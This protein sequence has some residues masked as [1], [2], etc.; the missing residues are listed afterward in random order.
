MNSTLHALRRNRK[1]LIGAAIMS[2]FAFLALVGPFLVADPQ[3]FV[4][5]PLTPPGS[6]FWFGT[7]GQGQ[8]VLA[9]TIVGA[10]STLAIGFFV[11]ILVT[12]IS[13]LIGISA[14]YFGGR[15]DDVLTLITNVF[16]VIPGLPLMVVLAAW[17][18][19]SPLSIILVLTFTGWA[20]GARILRA[21][22]MAIR[23]QDFVAAAI[24]SGESHLRIIFQQLLPNMASLMVAGFI[25][26]TMAAIGA[27]VALE[28]L[29]LGDVGA[30]TWGTNLYWAINDSALITGSWWTFVPTGICLAL[31][32]FGM[33]LL[34][35][36]ID[37]VTNPRLAAETHFAK[38]LQA[39]TPG[40]TP[41]VRKS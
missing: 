21:Q 30:V 26:T 11:G 5:R 34:N 16:L 8:D 2:S 10:R 40:T 23:K 22:T 27:Q 6:D 24:V 39:V 37:E 14:A 33:T 28:F 29:G 35:F 17:L 20:W 12:L 3:A 1:A 4:G 7:T 25:G 15:V 13:A 31:V 38:R 9:Q 36:A 41:V 18:P 19:P 32:G